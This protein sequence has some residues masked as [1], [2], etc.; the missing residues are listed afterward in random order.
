MGIFDFFRRKKKELKGETA[1]TESNA[2]MFCFVLAEDPPEVEADRANSIV[3][4]IL[5]PAYSADTSDANIVSIN[6]GKDTIGFLAKMPAPI[7][8]EEAEN[9]A[10]DNFLW[11]NGR[12]EVAR[13]NCHIIV[14][15]AGTGEF[16]PV[17]AVIG[18]AR[19][20]LVALE[21]YDGLGVYW[22]NGNVCNNRETFENFCED[23]SEEHVPLPVIM[24]FQF[25]S[26]DNNE[27]GLY[28][29]GMNQFGLMEIEVDHTS[30]ELSDL[31]EYVSNVA[32]Y[33]VMSGPV[34]SDGNTIGSD[35]NEKI[36]VRHQPSMIDKSRKVYKILFE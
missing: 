35:E 36:T 32:H 10:D 17:E 26:T 25:V 27:I 18:I 34:I 16:T 1:E 2:P 22:G 30:M 4:R 7:P 3:R 31:F 20:A 5:G 13:H 11:P 6:K 9:N 24:R 28:T 21:L 15:I 19:L 33:L 12:E 14:T 23:I 29:L 8:N